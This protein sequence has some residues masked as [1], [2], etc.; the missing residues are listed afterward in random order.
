MYVC[1]QACMKCLYIFLPVNNSQIN[2]K[3]GSLSIKTASQPS[4]AVGLVSGL[5]CMTKDP[6][7]SWWIISHKRIE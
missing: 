5:G 7:L 1:M 2:I 6:H 3:A 4:K